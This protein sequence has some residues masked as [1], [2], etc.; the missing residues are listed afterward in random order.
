[1]ATRRFPPPRSI[2]ELAECFVVRDA[3]GQALGYFYFDDEPHRRAVNK[4][5]TKD[6]ARRIA[7][8]VA[9]LP[10]LL[11]SGWGHRSFTDAARENPSKHRVSTVRI[12]RGFWPGSNPNGS[13]SMPEYRPMISKRC[14]C[15]SKRCAPMANAR[16]G[17]SR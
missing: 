10:G 8:N 13:P 16:A 6:E 4:R 12:W 5:L 11:R 1:M 15:S 7:A 2:E 17:K 14:P 3:N 9:K